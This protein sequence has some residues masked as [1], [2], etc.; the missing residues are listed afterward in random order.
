MKIGR[1]SCKALFLLVMTAPALGTV[2]PV[3]GKPGIWAATATYLCSRWNGKRMV[4]DIR[5]SSPDRSMVVHVLNDH[6]QIEI[7]ANKYSLG[8]EDSYVSYYPAEL[9][10]A[11]DGKAFYITQ[12][13]A[14]SEI[15]G[16]HTEVFGVTD[17]RI[18]K[19]AGLQELLISDF[20]IRH[21]CVSHS[22]GRRFTE[23]P[24]IAGLGWLEGSKKLLL[25]VESPPDSSC[26]RGYFGTYLISLEP[27][28]ILDRYSPSDTKAKWRNI[29]GNRIKDDLRSLSYQE[30]RALP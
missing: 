1:L 10:W 22:Q 3:E 19:I 18:E 20:A 2:C 21:Q 11:P 7:G 6:W 27:R 17:N 30:S 24:N 15:D 9:K 29:I 28:R 14:T 16:F 25:I 26:N 12:S 13:D 4:R 23:T 5:V 8:P